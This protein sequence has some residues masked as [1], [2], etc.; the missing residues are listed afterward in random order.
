MPGLN[1]HL[2]LHA[3]RV[4][5]LLD[6]HRIGSRHRACNRDGDPGQAHPGDMR[7]TVCPGAP[8]EPGLY[9][10]PGGVEAMLGGSDQGLP[11]VGAGGGCRDGLVPVEREGELGAGGVKVALPEPEQAGG[12]QR[13]AAAAGRRVESEQFAEQLPRGLPLA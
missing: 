9:R 4:R 2:V 1:E 13:P 5:E 6:P 11:R 3:G 12:E 10:S 8:A 7:G